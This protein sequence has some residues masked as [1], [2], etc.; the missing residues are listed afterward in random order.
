[1]APRSRAPEPADCP[2]LAQVATGVNAGVL[3][4]RKNKRWEW[5]LYL[6]DTYTDTL[7]IKINSDIKHGF[8][9]DL[10]QT[11]PWF[12]QLTLVF[13]SSVPTPSLPLLTMRADEI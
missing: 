12:R 5:Q 1:M 10:R 3:P 9:V 4:W 13:L 8:L 7:Y 6:S 2:G 11:A